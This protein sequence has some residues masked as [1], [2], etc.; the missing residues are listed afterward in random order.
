MVTTV[1]LRRIYCGQYSF[2]HFTEKPNDTCKAYIQICDC[3]C[4]A[5]HVTCTLLFC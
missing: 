1:E 2:V 4:A 5:W 3:D